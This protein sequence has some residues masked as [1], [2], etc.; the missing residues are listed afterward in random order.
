MLRSGQDRA[1]F[2]A[3]ILR[4]PESTRVEHDGQLGAHRPA[5][6]GESLAT[7]LDLFMTEGRALPMSVAL[8]VAMGIAARLEALGTPHGDLVPHHVLLGFDGTVHLLDPAG[9]DAMSFAR[10]PGRAGYR[11]PEHVDG[12]GIDSC[13]DI[14]LLGVLLF[15]MTTGTRLFDT[16]APELEERIRLVQVP[17]P[18]DVVGDGYPIE[19]QLVL[20]KLTRPSRAGRFPTP[21]AAQDAL[22]L[23]AT[24]RADVGPGPLSSWLRTELADRQHAW[25]DV[26]DLPGA[27]PAAV[28]ARAPSR[29]QTRPASFLGAGAPTIEEL[30]LDSPALEAVR[31]RI[32]EESQNSM[33]TVDDDLREELAALKLRRTELPAIP[34]ASTEPTSPGARAPRSSDDTYEELDVPTPGDLSPA[35]R[36]A[37]T[38]DEVEPPPAE[39]R[40]SP[41][42]PQGLASSPPP[43]LVPELP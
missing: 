21:R 24:T 30:R 6:V 19:L 12:H 11:A 31:R 8:T 1:A 29:A 27:E 35:P 9:P 22:R 32:V 34:P 3:S 25:A 37:T 23:V 40:R 36:G 33:R 5:V 39:P 16:E 41:R 38:R 17:R 2:E 42:R 43:N 10:V 13:T 7:V 26:A 28:R 14:F 15:E 20:R 4:D 18:R